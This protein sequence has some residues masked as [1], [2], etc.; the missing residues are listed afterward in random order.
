[1]QGIPLFQAISSSKYNT[2]PERN[3]P[4]NTDNLEQ[5]KY[6]SYGTWKYVKNNKNDIKIKILGTCEWF[7]NFV[8]GSPDSGHSWLNVRQITP[9]NI[10]SYSIKILNK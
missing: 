5:I 10:T 7:L 4:L 1:M 9:K 8:S 2:C 6:Q 3:S